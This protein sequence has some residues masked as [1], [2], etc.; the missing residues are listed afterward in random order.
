MNPLHIFLKLPCSANSVP[1]GMSLQSTHY[2][3]HIKLVV[4]SFIKCFGLAEACQRGLEGN[5]TEGK[6][7][8]VE[9]QSAIIHTTCATSLSIVGN[10]H[11]QETVCGQ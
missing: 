1:P 11:N 10:Y 2:S 4:T 9:G 3:V 5:T 8:E 6:Q 7:G